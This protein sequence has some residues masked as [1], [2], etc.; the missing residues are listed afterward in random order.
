MSNPFLQSN[1]K[2]SKKIEIKNVFEQK[3]FSYYLH[4][5]IFIH[6]NNSFIIFKPIYFQ[7]TYRLFYANI[8]YM[9]YLFQGGKNNEK[10]F[11]NSDDSY[12]I[13]F[14]WV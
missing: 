14:I 13:T 4:L 1:K 12:V 2:Y 5:N 11:S 9:T 10:I 7:F 8:I 3:I 6:T